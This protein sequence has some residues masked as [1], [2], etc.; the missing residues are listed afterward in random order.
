MALVFTITEMNA[1]LAEVFPQV[2]GMFG[3]DQMDEDLLVMRLMVSDSH[4]RPGGTVSGP[5]MFA[6]A[7][8]SAY[9]ATLARIGR[10]ALTVTTHCSIDFMRKP[11][12][13][14]DL[15]AQARLL[16]LGRT[17][18]VTDV[19]MYSEGSATPVAHASLTYSI[20]PARIG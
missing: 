19:L 1:Y 18:S 17:L 16:K 2:D 13:G 6:L 4:L 10:Q 14:R 8:V 7:D 9:V 15:L 12:S 3:I 20:P 11:E 5:S